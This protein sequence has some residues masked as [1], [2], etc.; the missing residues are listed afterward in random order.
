MRPKYTSNRGY[1]ESGHVS[2]IMDHEMGFV[3][4]NGW[5][6]GDMCRVVICD[7]WG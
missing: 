2:L 6:D 1:D 5:F 4:S 7:D 3:T